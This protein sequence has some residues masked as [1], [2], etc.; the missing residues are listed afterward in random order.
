MAVSE[1]QMREMQAAVSAGMQSGA[2]AP[3]MRP[4]APAAPAGGLPPSAPAVDDAKMREMQAAVSAGMQQ[5]KTPETTGTAPVR[6]AA[7]TR[8]A[9]PPPAAGTPEPTWGETAVGAATAFLPSTLNAVR[10]LGSAVMS[11]I[12][13]LQGL[14]EIGKGLLSKGAGGVGLEQDP[15]EKAKNEAVLNAVIDD[16]AKRYGSEAEFKRALMTDPASILM[17]MTTL[18]SGGSTGAARALGATSAAGKVAGEV[19]RGVQFLD[20]LALAQKTVGVGASGLGHTL[21]WALSKTSGVPKQFLDI[22]SGIADKAPEAGRDAFFR[23]LRGEGNPVELSTKLDMAFREMRREASNAF[24]SKFP[25]FRNNRVDLTDAATVATDKLTR[26]TTAGAEELSTEQ[27]AKLR[28]I[29]N[30]IDA[31]MADPSRQGLENIHVLKRQIDEK[32]AETNPR[33]Q[34]L[35]YG[36]LT[37][38]RRQVRDALSDPRRGGNTEYADLMDQYQMARNEIAD[39]EYH[40]GSRGGAS[41]RL[42]SAINRIKKSPY[43]QN[44][45]TRIGQIDPEIPAALAGASMRAWDSSGAETLA[46]AAA[47]VG[48]YAFVHPAGAAAIIPTMPRVVGSGLA[49]S[50]YGTRLGRAATGFGPQRAAYL[51]SLAGGVG[52]GMEAPP[53]ERAKQASET[54]NADP[55]FSAML[56]RESGNDHWEIDKRTGEKTPKISSAGAIGIAQVMPRTGPDAAKLAGEEWSL[57]RLK[58]DPAYNA[59]LGYAYYQEMLRQFD[60]DPYVAAAAYNA[61]PRKVREAFQKARAG[62]GNYL[63]YL[64]PETQNYVAAVASATERPQRASGGKVVGKQQMLVDRLM[65]RVKQAHEKITQDTKPLL[66]VP[67]EA[68]AQALEVANKAI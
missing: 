43:S 4:S 58:N 62:S 57:D 45:L 17:D 67:D 5:T 8:R 25:R 66:N 28:G 29:K 16:Y 24:F 34:S 11:P 35:L 7:V 1:D 13:T 53:D 40:M 19:A 30:G 50:S 37:E 3:P 36:D 38:I 41:P 32:I 51:G 52:E 15:E 48:L 59:R 65:Q 31:I 9:P 21:K 39:I 10:Q 27:I 46:G 6:P 18:I 42:A 2:P 54:I 47:S 12:Q 49:A 22:A 55:V 44:A 14:K 64:K 56:Q 23:F 20:P 61:G 60:G 26:A 68:V 33:T 63:D